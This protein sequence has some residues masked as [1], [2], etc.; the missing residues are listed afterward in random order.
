LG[1]NFI[2]LHHTTRTA[3]IYAYDKS[4]KPLKGVPIVAGATAYDDTASGL[5]YILIF[6][7]TL[8]YGSKLDHTLINPNQV[9]NY[10]IGFCDNPFDKERGLL[11]DVNDELWIPMYTYGT[12]IQFLSRKPTVSELQTCPRIILSSAMAWN[13]TQV[14]LSEASTTAPSDDLP[15][16]R[17]ST[18]SRV[19][20]MRQYEYLDPSSDEA[21]LHSIDPSFVHLRERLIAKTTRYDKDLEDAPARRTFVSTDRHSKITSDHIAERFGIGPERAKATLRGMRLAILPIGRRYRGD[22]MFDVKR[23][24]GKFATD[25]LWATTKSLNSNVATQIYTHKCGFNAAYH[26]TRANGE[27]VEYSLSSFIHEYGAPDHLTFD[28]AAVHVGSSTRF[29]ENLRRAEIRHHVSAPRRPNENPAEGSIREVKKRWYRMMLKK[30]VPARLWDYGISWICETGN[31]IANS[32]RYADQRTPLEI[33]TGETP[34]ITEYLDFTIYDW[35]TFKTN[36][37]VAPPELGR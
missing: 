1:K 30:N 15:K 27:Q 34:D 32:S 25:T 22:R 10:G 17:E 35:V 9:R 24:R 33:I 13:P 28:G 37:G 16:I 7:E 3:D 8:Y 6:N 23:L 11:I 31:V 2:I 18:I 4:Y 36:A 29:M 21:L 12:K 20:S 5:K 14:V 19:G 26:L